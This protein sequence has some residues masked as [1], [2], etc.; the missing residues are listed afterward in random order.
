MSPKN[1]QQK[2]KGVGERV[3]RQNTLLS[4]MDAKQGNMRYTRGDITFMMMSS[5][6]KKNHEITLRSE[7]K[8]RKI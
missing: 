4:V 2:K 5:R 1:E 3:K 6:R 8:C 7:R